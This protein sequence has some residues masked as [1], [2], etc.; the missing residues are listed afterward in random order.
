[1]NAKQRKVLLVGEMSNTGLKDKLNTVPNLTLNTAAS[2]IEAIGNL[3]G[4]QFD[5]IVVFE[6]VEGLPLTQTLSMIQ[7]K[8][9]EAQIFLCD[10]GPSEMPNIGS[11]TSS[12]LLSLLAPNANSTSFSLDLSRLKDLAKGDEAFVAEMLGMYLEDLP[13]YVSSLT[14]AA[15]VKDWIALGKAAHKLKAP[16]NMVGVDFLNDKLIKLDDIGQEDIT[17][18]SDEVDQLMSDVAS[19]VEVCLNVREDLKTRLS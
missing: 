10:G 11:I 4:E 6:Q 3:H 9:G 7:K 15:E 18:K 5:I 12:E 2:A 1:M 19:I 16:L 14:E 17:P 13:G 8:S